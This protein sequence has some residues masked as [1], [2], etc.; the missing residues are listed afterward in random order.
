MKNKMRTTGLILAVL[1]VVFL[2]G[3]SKPELPSA[4]RIILGEVLTMAS[5]PIYVADAKGFW[6]EE[7]LEVEIKS[8]VSGRLGLDALV[9]NG[10][11][12]ATVSD[13]PVLFAA[14][15]QQPVRIV[16]T[17]TNSEKHVNMIGRKD[18]GVFKPED[19]KGKRVAVS[20]GTAAEFVMDM[21]LERYGLTRSDIKIVALTPPDT[22]AA[23]VR[24]DVDVNFAWQPYIYNAQKQLGN[25][26][27]VFPSEGNYNH[28]FSVVVME[29]YLSKGQEELR[30]L[31]KGLKRAEQFMRDNR[32]ESIEIVAKKLGVETQDIEAIWDG[33]SFEV[34]LDSSLVSLLEQEGKWA[35][36]AGIV[37]Q[38][39]SE[40]D[41]K[42]IVYEELLRDLK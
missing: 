4:K 32:A 39:M 26:A 25:N 12:V 14:F 34:G 31:I 20:L 6:K 28:P 37:T 35:K 1:I 36:R 40:P 15:Q 38:D 41:Y 21:F 7:N 16:A 9:A 18:R 29:D 23:I 3:C 8:F 24:G 33:Y 11:N 42:S 2:T 17:F 22:V 10:V 27:V 19:I 13:I 30:K 5:A